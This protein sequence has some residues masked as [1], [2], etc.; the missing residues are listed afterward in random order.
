M[1]LRFAATCPTSTFPRYWRRCSISQTLV[2]CQNYKKCF[3]QVVDRIWLH[4]SW[5]R[6]I[7]EA[8][9]KSVRNT[10][11]RLSK[12]NHLTR[13]VSSRSHRPIQASSGKLIPRSNAL[14]VEKTFRRQKRAFTYE[15]LS[16]KSY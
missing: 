5:K 6:S 8:N 10:Q 13:F 1:T 3:R 4:N 11:K 12:F 14:A 9:M 7:A 15:A 16:K 2:L